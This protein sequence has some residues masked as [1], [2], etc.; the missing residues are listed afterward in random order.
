M[1]LLDGSI[2]YFESDKFVWEWYSFWSPFARTDFY[3]VTHT[4]EHTHDSHCLERWKELYQTNW[5]EVTTRDTE[6]WWSV[7]IL[8]SH[9]LKDV[10]TLTCIFIFKKWKE[11][12]NNI[13]PEFCY[14]LVSLCA[15][16]NLT[17]PPS[18]E[19]ICANTH[20]LCEG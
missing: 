4:S 19:G 8:T 3:T 11:A 1:C 13:S 12:Y 16:I 14:V 2:F 20:W 17:L 7:G 18:P 10:A 9:S 6:I 15:Q 5:E